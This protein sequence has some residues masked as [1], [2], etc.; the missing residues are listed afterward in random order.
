MLAFYQTK[1]LPTYSNGFHSN[2]AFI[3]SIR[4][5]YY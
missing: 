2:T 5:L 4:I 1:Y 3:Y